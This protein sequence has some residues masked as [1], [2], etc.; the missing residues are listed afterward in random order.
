VVVLPLSGRRTLSETTFLQLG[1]PERGRPGGPGGRARRR[2]WRGGRPRCMPWRR[3]AGRV[4]LVQAPAHGARAAATSASW[5]PGVVGRAA[6]GPSPDERSRSPLLDME[7]SFSS[8]SVAEGEPLAGHLAAYGWL[9][10][11][12]PVPRVPQHPPDAMPDEGRQPGHH[13]TPAFTRE[14]ARRP[15]TPGLCPGRS[16]VDRG[17]ADRTLAFRR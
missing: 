11:V 8:Q 3:R 17:S 12:E 13:T 10:P 6:R 4:E 9:F 2:S 5:S 7:H 15:P 16:A 1:R 14:R